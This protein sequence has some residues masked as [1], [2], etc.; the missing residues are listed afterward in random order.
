MPLPV[1][2]TGRGVWQ[3]GRWY[4]VI[5]RPLSTND[6]LDYQFHPGGRGQLCVAV[7]DGGAGNVGG[8][9]HYSMWIDFAMVP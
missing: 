3:D 8:R 1:S 2:K 7:W 6:A 9:K 5:A 4:V